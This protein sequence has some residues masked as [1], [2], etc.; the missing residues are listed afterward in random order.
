M[1]VAYR[2]CKTR[3]PVFDGTGAAIGGGRWNSRGRPLIYCADS[4]A[5]AL[6]EILVHANAPVALPGPHH[7]ARAVFPDGL[8]VEILKEGDLPGWADENPSPSRAFGDRWLDE[9]RTAI[10]SVPAATAR[11]YGRNLL[12]NPVHPDFGRIILEAEVPVAWDAR[13]FRAR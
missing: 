9:Q 1:H 4:F 8:A 7:C 6:L 12:L 2:V 10:L 11:P 5:G 13:L 3:Y